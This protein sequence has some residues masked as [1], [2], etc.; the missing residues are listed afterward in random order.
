MA[1]VLATPQVVAATE[2]GSH[3]F[4]NVQSAPLR[5]HFNHGGGFHRA[6]STI[7]RHGDNGALIRHSMRAC[8]NWFAIGTQ[9]NLPN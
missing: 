7:S 4:S 2:G 5:I 1:N 8:G 3:R 6:Q 9:A